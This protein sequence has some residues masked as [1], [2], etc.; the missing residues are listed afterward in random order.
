[1]QAVGDSKNV[2]PYAV[3][4]Y[5]NETKVCRRN[6]CRIALCWELC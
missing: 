3:N 1:M 4:R 6:G 5:V 2:V